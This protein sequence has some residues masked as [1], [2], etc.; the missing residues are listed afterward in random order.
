MEG[1]RPRSFDCGAGSHFHHGRV[2]GGPPIIP[3]RPVFP[4]PVRSLGHRFF[5]GP[6]HPQR[7]LSVDS[8]TPR[9]L[10]VCSRPSSIS[11]VRLIAGCESG[12]LGFDDTTEY[13]ESLCPM[14]ALPPWERRGPS[15]QRALPLLLRSYGLMR[16]S[17]HLSPASALAS[18]ASLC[19]LPS[20]PAAHGTF[21]TIFCESFLG[22]LSPY[23]GGFAACTCL[24]LPQRHRPSP[25]EKWVGFPLLSREHDFSRT[26]IS[27][28]QLFLYVQA[29][30]FACLPGRSYRC[31]FPLQGSRGFYVRAER[32]S[33]PS[34]A[35]DMLSARLQ[36]IGRTRTFT[37]QGS[38][39]CRLLLSNEG[40]NPSR[41]AISVPYASVP[42]ALKC[43][44][45]IPGQDASVRAW[46]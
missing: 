30:E 27:R 24:V 42:Y 2:S 3:G 26:P 33:I 17:R 22:C 5:L 9:L 41:C 13:L 44:V 18:L 46:L 35:S 16:R 12:H 34:H 1:Y 32:A 15:L 20:A 37:S 45:S 23:P 8:H 11:H 36:A 14:L 31:K 38:R 29:S 7:G 10:L 40:F 4:G 39:H 25:N 19:R 28:L 43:F 21:S 6:S